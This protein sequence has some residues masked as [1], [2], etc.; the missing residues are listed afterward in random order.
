MTSKHTPGDWEYIK[1]TGR[2][3]SGDVR[4]C[5]INGHMTDTGHANG[6]MLAASLDLYYAARAAR[7]YLCDENR[8]ADDLLPVIE[9][10]DASISKAEG[11]AA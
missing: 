11:G 1:M 8:R 10:L 2:V 5:G 6:R 7:K 9:A 3:L 4:I